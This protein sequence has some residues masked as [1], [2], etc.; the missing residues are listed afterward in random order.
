MLQLTSAAG[1]SP[2]DPTVSI[3]PLPLVSF[4]PSDELYK[5]EYENTQGSTRDG[6]LPSYFFLLLLQMFVD[7]GL[8]TIRRLKRQHHPSSADGRGGTGFVVSR[9]V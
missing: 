6:E 8:G 3:L 1:S 4:P 5:R 7:E 2:L 9:T